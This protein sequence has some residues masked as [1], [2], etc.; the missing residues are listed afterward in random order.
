MR[1][2]LESDTPSTLSE[3]NGSEPEDLLSYLSHLQGLKI[4]AITAINEDM[5]QDFTGKY[6]FLGRVRGVYVAVPVDSD[7]QII[8]M[9]ARFVGGEGED[10]LRFYGIRQSGSTPSHITVIGGTGRYDGANGCATLK[11]VGD[12]GNYLSVNIILS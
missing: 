9:T 5:T 10:S 8:A 11:R 3:P 6:P 4:G 7:E 12:V 1:D 2:T